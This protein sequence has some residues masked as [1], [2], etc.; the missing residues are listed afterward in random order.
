M[1][2]K[3][4]LTINKDDESGSISCSCGACAYIGE[5]ELKMIKVLV[6]GEITFKGDVTEKNKGTFNLSIDK[7]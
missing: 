3:I 1:K 5:D 4:E 6:D 2:H 7:N